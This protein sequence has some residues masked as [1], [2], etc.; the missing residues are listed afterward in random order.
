MV[1]VES[2]QERMLKM[3]HERNGMIGKLSKSIAA[4]RKYLK[5]A[6]AN[7]RFHKTHIKRTEK[8]LKKLKER[9]HGQK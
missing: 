4:S 5:E 2:T 1:G 3:G 7:V 6:K 9:N 8:L